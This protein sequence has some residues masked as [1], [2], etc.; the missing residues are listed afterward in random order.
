MYLNIVSKGFCKDFA[1]NILTEDSSA[2]FDFGKIWWF[3]IATKDLNGE[4]KVASNQTHIKSKMM[5]ASHK[6]TGHKDL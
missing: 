1:D 5:D 6:R 4:A 2:K 3:M